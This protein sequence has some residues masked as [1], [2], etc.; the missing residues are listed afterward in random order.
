MAKK[1]AKLIISVAKH[2]LTGTLTA[3]PT[4][5]RKRPSY[6]KELIAVL[7]NQEV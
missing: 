5:I 3:D 6:K 1:D 4:S 2:N 7:H